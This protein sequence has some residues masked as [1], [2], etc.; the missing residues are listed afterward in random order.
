VPHL[1]FGKL[2]RIPRWVLLRHVADSSGSPIPFEVGLADSAEQ[3]G[4]ARQPDAEDK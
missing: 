3:S 1:R 2:I 4:S